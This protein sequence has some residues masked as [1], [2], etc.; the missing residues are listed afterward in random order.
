VL[1]PGVIE[2]EAL[3]VLFYVDSGPL[4]NLVEPLSDPTNGSSGRVEHTWVKPVPENGELTFTHKADF[5]NFYDSE[6]ST[7]GTDIVL[8]VPTGLSAAATACLN[9]QVGVIA[10]KNIDVRIVLN[11]ET[12]PE[13]VGYFKMYASNVLPTQ[14]IK[15]KGIADNN[16]RYLVSPAIDGVVK[17]ETLSSASSATGLTIPF[18]QWFPIDAATLAACLAM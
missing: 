15:L 11:P 9:Q 2:H 8:D 18:E 17:L 6:I 7:M 10:K 12:A 14:P 16:S 5:Q 13:V 1:L 3:Q 4:D